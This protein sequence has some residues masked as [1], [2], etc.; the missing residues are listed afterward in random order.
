MSTKRRRRLRAATLVAA[1]TVTG[2][3][4]LAGPGLASSFGMGGDEVRLDRPALGNVFFSSRFARAEIVVVTGGVPRAIRIDRGRARA[5]SP[6][7]VTLLERDGTLVTIPVASTAAIRV[8]GR[9]GA[10]TEIRRGAIVLTARDGDAPATTV[11]AQ[12][13]GR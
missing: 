1:L 11:V 12:G 5:A 10:L 6:G 7:A 8:N 3:V 13:R 4:L 2:T 9:P